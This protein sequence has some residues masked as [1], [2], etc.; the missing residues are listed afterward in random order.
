LRAL[1]NVGAVR[2]VDSNG[3]GAHDAAS[4]GSHPDKGAFKT[5]SYAVSVIPANTLLVIRENHAE[6]A[7]YDGAH[8]LWNAAGIKLLGLGIGDERPMLTLEG[9]LTKIY[10]TQHNLAFIN[11]RFINRSADMRA[12]IDVAKPGISVINCSMHVGDGT[13]SGYA[14]IAVGSDNGKFVGNEIITT[15]AGCNSGIWLDADPSA[16][17]NEI[18]HNWV[19]GDFSDAALYGPDTEPHTRLRVHHNIFSNTRAASYAIRL[20][21][22]A[23]T[24][25]IAYNTVNCPRAAVGT[26]GAIDPASCVCCENYGSDGV[27]DVSGVLNPAADAA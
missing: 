9:S 3:D 14:G 15:G 13:Y 8:F 22:N 11:L 21:D 7:S 4:A 16:S 17:D 26:K 20:V 19:Y 24:G 27:G 23:T 25:V 1:F 5:V 12:F 6:T 2:Y 18:A 10:A